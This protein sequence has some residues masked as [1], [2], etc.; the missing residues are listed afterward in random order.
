MVFA[1]CALVSGVFP[2]AEYF[3]A[4]EIL[5]IPIAIHAYGLCIHAMLSFSVA[6]ILDGIAASHRYIHAIQLLHWCDR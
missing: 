5:H 6:V 2:V 4:G 1:I 3:R